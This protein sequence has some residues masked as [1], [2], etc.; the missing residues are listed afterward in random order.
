MDRPKL[1]LRGSGVRKTT[2][3]TYA[4]VGLT[5]GAVRVM[6]YPAGFVS[7]GAFGAA[8]A[9]PHNGVLWRLARLMLN[10]ARALLGLYLLAALMLLIAV[11]VMR[12]RRPLAS[13]PAR[14]RL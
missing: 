6:Y 7:M 1:G 4:D 13:D 12:F 9:L 5:V 11:K 8:V 2:L 3:T 14:A 10:A